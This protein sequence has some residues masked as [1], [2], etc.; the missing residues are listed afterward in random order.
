MT[1]DLLAVSA[2]LV[3]QGRD[4]IALEGEIALAAG[5]V[6]VLLAPFFSVRRSNLISGAIALVA[7]LV[8]FLLTFRTFPEA[9]F[10]FRKLL[11]LD[12][13]A[14]FWEQVLLIFMIGVILLWFITTR[15]ALKDGDGPEFFT[16]VLASTA[17]MMLMGQTT[18]LLLI[19]LATEIASMPSYVLAGFRKNRRNAAEGALKF[20][21]FGAVCTAIMIYGC[22]LLYGTHASLSIDAIAADIK[23]GG[24]LPLTTVIGLLAVFVGLLFKISGVP[25]HFWAPD[26]LEGTSADVAVFLSV[27]SKSAGIVMLARVATILAPA[28]A[29]LQTGMEIA[30][31]VASVASMIVGNLGAQQQVSV[32]RML[33]YSSIAHAGYMMGA[34]ALLR[35]ASIDE[36]MT[37]LGIYLAIYLF[38]QLGA[39]AVVGEVETATGSDHIESFRGLSILSP[40]SAAALAV[41]M[42]SMIGLPPFG[43]FWAKLK[44]MILLA[45]AG[46]WWWVVVMSVAINS[47]ISVGFYGR[48][49]R[50]MYLEKTPEQPARYALPT[51]LIGL[52][53]AIALLGTFILLSPLEHTSERMADQWRVVAETSASP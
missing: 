28:H 26:V 48:V 43:G 27:A 24:T 19:V 39:F 47:I 13:A 33:A 34:V 38:M 30:I 37:V 32:K 16:L 15:K 18:N 9:G 49:L 44:V 5:I 2:P 8:A 17:G 6:G 14:I 36:A 35:P 50:A 52:A 41:A 20:V 45:Q 51:G 53:C 3:P 22:S 23:A 7:I 11:V 29:G 21:L 46:G 10:A 4:F 1:A 31:A 42:L 12:P 25:L 40:L